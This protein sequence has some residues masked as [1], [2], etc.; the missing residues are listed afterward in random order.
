MGEFHG[1]YIVDKFYCLE[2]P[3]R[4]K[5]LLLFPRIIT[6]RVWAVDQVGWRPTTDYS[7]IQGIC[8]Q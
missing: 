4:I 3:L 5:N 1:T 8:V 6:I 2:S 7:V